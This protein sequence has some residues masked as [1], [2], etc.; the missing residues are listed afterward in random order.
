MKSN[1]SYS[2]KVGREVWHGDMGKKNYRK[3]QHGPSGMT[4]RSVFGKQ[5]LEKQY[6]R[7][8]YG[9]MEKTM[10]NLMKRAKKMKGNTI[11]NIALLLESRLATL[12][13]RANFAKSIFAA[14][15]MVLH[16]KVKVNGKRINLR[17]YN[18]K[19]G[20]VV[21]IVEPY[22]S[23]E[24]LNSSI[25]NPITQS[26]DYIVVDKDKYSVSLAREPGFKEIPFP[27]KGIDSNLIISYYSRRL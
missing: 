22:R 19:V 8:H 26:P 5:L 1:G 15:Q 12:L 11:D 23:N 24:N 20:D 14:G 17:G 25:T 27:F 21:E 9:L 6:V 18:V 2:R 13:Y 7:Y 10:F 4:K 3:G 16:G